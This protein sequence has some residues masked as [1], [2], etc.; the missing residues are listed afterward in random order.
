MAPPDAVARAARALRGGQVVVIPTDTVYG[1]AVDPTQP[2]AT[3]R[4]FA[5]KQRPRG[6]ALPVLV[7]G[8]DQIEALVDAVA[9]PAAR[10][11]DRFWPGALTLILTRRPGLAWDLGG[12]AGT[13]GVRCADHPVPAALCRE[14]GPLATTSANI[15]ARPTPAAAADVA[16]ELGAAVAV[17]VDAGRCDRAPS[18][19]VDCTAG[20][21]SVRLV[22]EGQIPWAGVKA[23]VG[24]PPHR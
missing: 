24:A 6:V 20:D 23:A 8:P 13:V 14:V 5:A 1:L 16:A 2:G 11:M 9:P 7:A 22:R 19:V 12:D 4:L 18:T 10:L 15:H 3:A 21:G 17:V